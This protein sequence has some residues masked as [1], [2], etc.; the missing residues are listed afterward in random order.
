[1]LEDLEETLTGLSRIYAIMGDICL[2]KGMQDAAQIY[3]RKFAGLNP[4]IP[5]TTDV[6]GES[7]P[8]PPQAVNAGGEGEEAVPVPSGFQTVTLAELYIRQG[9]IRQAAEV[10]EA[11]L[12]G[13]P[14]QEKAVSLLQSLREA[15]RREASAGSQP[16]IVAELS[17]WLDN[18]HRLRG[19]AA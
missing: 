2:K 10:L 15:I 9:H 16:G 7:R 13:D 4:D 12:R 3:Y 1:M 11:V 18:I 8:V 6:S 19:H 14:H 17:R 5:L